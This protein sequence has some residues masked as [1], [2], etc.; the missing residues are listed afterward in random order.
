MD[1]TNT[2]LNKNDNQNTQITFTDILKEK[3]I[4]YIDSNFEVFKNK[5]TIQCSKHY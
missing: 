1:N 2:S 3:M 5:T 4:N